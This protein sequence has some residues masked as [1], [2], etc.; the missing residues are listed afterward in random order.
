MK[1]KKRDPLRRT[2]TR[3]AQDEEGETVASE[4]RSG[5]TTRY[6]AFDDRARLVPWYSLLCDALGG[7][8][9]SFSFIISH[10]ISREARSQLLA[11]DRLEQPREDAC[12]PQG[13]EASP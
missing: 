12:S 2:H 9:N 13:G 4:R 6:C 8:H 7:G 3:Y 5:N 10:D 1:R 11:L